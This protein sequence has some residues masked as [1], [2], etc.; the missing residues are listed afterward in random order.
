MLEK[1]NDE[2]RKV[3]NFFAEVGLPI[4]LAQMS[5]NPKDDMEKL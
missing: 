2:A 5:L 3:G 1:R 4:N